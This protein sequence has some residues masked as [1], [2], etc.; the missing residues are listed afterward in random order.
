M[1]VVTVMG[2]GMG[3]GMGMVMGTVM[4]NGTRTARAL[5]STACFS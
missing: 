2:M 5:R 3:M 1:A 4:A